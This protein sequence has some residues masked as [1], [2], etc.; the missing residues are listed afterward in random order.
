MPDLPDLTPAKGSGIR[1]R[2]GPL[3]L[4]GWGIVVAGGVVAGLFLFRRRDSSTSSRTSRVTG[5]RTLAGGS[6]PSS[7]SGS[8]GGGGGGGAFG[9]RR[10]SP[11]AGGG[12]PLATILPGGDANEGD[13]ALNVPSFDVPRVGLDTGP[14]EDVIEAVAVP[15]RA[16]IAPGRETESEPAPEPRFR[17]PDVIP[18][19]VADAPDFVRRAFGQPVATAQDAATDIALAGQD[20]V[21]RRLPN[22]TNLDTLGAEG[23]FF[24]PS[25]RSRVGGGVTQIFGADENARAAEDSNVA[26]ARGPGLEQAGQLIQDAT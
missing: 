6:P 12:G 20:T 19:F 15:A 11:V 14:V 2:V 8:G 10:R 21:R 17:I 24:D 5:S 3:P 9:P 4:W 25:G 26:A 23:V 1:R 16:L 22:P 13:T 7:R 18:A